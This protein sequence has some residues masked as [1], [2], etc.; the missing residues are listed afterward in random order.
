[1]I[2]SFSSSMMTFPARIHRTNSVSVQLIQSNTGVWKFFAI[3][4]AFCLSQSPPSPPLAPIS[5]KN[6]LLLP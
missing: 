2:A 5:V 4:I 6:F 3:R 1:M